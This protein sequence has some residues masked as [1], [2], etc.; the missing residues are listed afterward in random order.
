MVQGVVN[1][2]ALEGWSYFFSLFGA[3]LMSLYL[4]P[5]GRTGD[6]WGEWGPSKYDWPF[7]CGRPV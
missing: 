4:L 5:D 1:F 6:V 2:T 3:A 7:R